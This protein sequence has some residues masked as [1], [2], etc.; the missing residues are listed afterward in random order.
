MKTT[1]P[2]TTEET[3]AGEKRRRHQ[4]MSAELNGPPVIGCG[5]CGCYFVRQVLAYGE[6]TSGA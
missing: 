4:G 2:A 5:S 3:F 6:Q 1:T